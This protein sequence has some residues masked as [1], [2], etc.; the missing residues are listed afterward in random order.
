MHFTESSTTGS[1][2]SCLATRRVAC[3]LSK[4][5]KHAHML[6]VSL[7]VRLAVVGAGTGVVIEGAGEADL[8]VAFTP[9][10][11]AVLFFR[12]F[13]IILSRK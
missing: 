7:Q 4:A 5:C 10:K 6:P 13:V 8:P 11:V 12:A 3:V 1:Q 9:T 2:A